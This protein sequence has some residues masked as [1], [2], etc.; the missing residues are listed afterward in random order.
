MARKKFRRSLRPE[1]QSDRSFQEYIQ[2]QPAALT[3][4]TELL[5]LIRGGEDTYLELKV[6][7]SNPERIAQGI[8]AL[9]N[10]DGGTIIFGVNDHLRIEGVPNPEWVQEELTR[11]CREDIYPPIVPVLDT[12]AFDSGKLVVALDVRGKRRPYRTMDGRFYMRFGA[13][14]REVTRAELSMWLDELRPLGFENIPLATVTEDDFDDAL[15]WSFA[16]AFDENG[17]SRGEYNTAQFLKKDLLLAVGT[18]DEFLPTVAG[19]LLFGRSDRVAEF[20]PRSAVTLA[21]FSG[22][23]GN[24]QLIEKAQITG[25]LLSQYDAIIKFLRR[26]V[27]LWTER[28]RRS[29]TVDHPTAKPRANYHAD[30]VAEAVAN[31]LIH[32]DLAL[33]EIPTRILI[34][35]DSIEFINPRR[36]GGFVP[37]ASRAIRYGV[38]QRLNPQIAAIFARE[39]YGTSVPAGGL[40]MILRRSHA[41]SGRR[42]E[43]YT[44]NDEFKLRIFGA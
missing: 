21:R 31:A 25:N 24:A 5:R 44:S 23:N 30:A 1:S 32:R 13:E 10:T 40:P 19:L 41:F 38:T 42:A 34:Y 27:D 8:V 17:S 20:I 35:D 26:Y 39:E 4:R 36:T 14:K 7:L 15:L 22:S 28:P 3:T 11:I 43:V 33:R 18:G 9:A 37:P 16:A 29:D 2:N 12:I 6:K